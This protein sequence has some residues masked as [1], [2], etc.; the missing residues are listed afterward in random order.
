M[1]AKNV[2]VLG[3]RTAD[4]RAKTARLCGFLKGAERVLGR[5]TLTPE[6]KQELLADFTALSGAVAAAYNSAK[7][8]MDA[9]EPI[10]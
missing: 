9:T 8:A 10:E 2:G 4:L 1:I 7:E 5:F 6:Q 3:K